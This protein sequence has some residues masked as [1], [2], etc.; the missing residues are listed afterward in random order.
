MRHR[1]GPQGLL[2]PEL[3][4]PPERHVDV[5][6]LIVGYGQAHLDEVDRVDGREGGPAAQELAHVHA[7][8]PHAAGEGCA[9]LGAGEVPLRL[10]Q[11]DALLTQLRAGDALRALCVIQGLRAHNVPGGESAPA[12]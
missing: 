6:E 11:R 5:G 3:A 7:L 10:G 1:L 12:L 9:E 2:A 8:L 4:A